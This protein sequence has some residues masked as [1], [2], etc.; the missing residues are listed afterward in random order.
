ML[1]KD[2][3]AVLLGLFK[4]WA[5]W[6][7]VYWNIARKVDRVRLTMETKGSVPNGIPPLCP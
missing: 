1:R 5:S 4:N 3:L 6:L 7:G 2:C